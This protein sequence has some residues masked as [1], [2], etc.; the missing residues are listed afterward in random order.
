MAVGELDEIVV[1]CADPASLAV[2]WARVLG[3]EPVDRSPDWSYV[4]PP[5]QTRVAFQRV[6]EPK[7]GKN[8]LHIDVAVA[9]IHAASAELAALGARLVGGIVTDTAGSFQVLLD[10]EGNEFCAVSGID[11]TGRTGAEAVR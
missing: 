5:G 9:D 3:G 6:P 8:R 10:P 7:S 11:R 2:F 4:D 1:D